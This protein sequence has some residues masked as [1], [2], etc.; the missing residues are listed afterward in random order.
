MTW[1]N[2]TSLEQMVRFLKGFLD[3]RENFLKGFLQEVLRFEGARVSSY[4]TVPDGGFHCE[5]FGVF[6]TQESGPRDRALS[7]PR[8]Y[9]DAYKSD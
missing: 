7:A 6:V 8:N 1:C 5:C 4:R 3:R 9:L 2:L